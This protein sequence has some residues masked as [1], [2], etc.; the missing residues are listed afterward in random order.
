VA[1]ATR[2]ATNHERIN[3][4]KKALCPTRPVLA[5]VIQNHPNRPVR[6]SAENL[7]VVVL[8]MALSYSEVGASGKP[9]AIHFCFLHENPS[10]EGR[11]YMKSIFTIS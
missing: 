9:G 2:N 11:T 5:F 8:V 6:T 7:F 1:V 10:A 4:R 3:L